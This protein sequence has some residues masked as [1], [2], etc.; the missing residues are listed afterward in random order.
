L[1]D[2]RKELAA[3]WKMRQALEKRLK[4]NFQKTVTGY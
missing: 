4:Y 2:V 3:E 1:A